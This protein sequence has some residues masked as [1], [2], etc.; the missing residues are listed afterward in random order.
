MPIKMYNKALLMKTNVSLGAVVGTGSDQ[1][2]ATD[3]Q[4]ILQVAVDIVDPGQLE[5]TQDSARPLEED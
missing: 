5:L 3:M 1:G 2:K 4:G